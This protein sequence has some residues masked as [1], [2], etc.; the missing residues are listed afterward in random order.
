MHSVLHLEFILGKYIIKRLFQIIFINSSQNR[1][2]LR[3]LQ[4]KIE[5]IH[6]NNELA[7]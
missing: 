5:S 1:F 3:E 2:L 6:T 4:I 7:S